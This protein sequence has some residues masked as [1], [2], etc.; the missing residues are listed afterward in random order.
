MVVSPHGSAAV[1]SESARRG[2]EP[3][4]LPAFAPTAG[5]LGMTKLAN[6][7]GFDSLLC[8]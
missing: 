5:V 1:L 2:Y 4:H 7:L 8:R 6:Q 3:H